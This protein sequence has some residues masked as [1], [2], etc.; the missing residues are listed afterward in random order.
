[1]KN[2]KNTRKNNFIKKIFIKLCRLLGFEIIDQSNF[3]VP[4]INKDL[5]ENLSIPGEKSIT[6]PLGEVK[7]IKKIKSLKIIIRTCTAELIMDQ[8]KKRLFDQEKS[9]YTF[10]SLYSLLKSIELAQNYFKD[11]IF[12]IIIYRSLILKKMTSKK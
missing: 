10:R 12:E 6:I 5:N 1:M 7:I 8:N 11:T 2:I 9:E 3:T 4:T